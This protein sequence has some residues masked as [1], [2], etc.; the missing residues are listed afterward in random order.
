MASWNGSVVEYFPPVRIEDRPGWWRLDCGC[1]AGIAWSASEYARECDSCKG[2]GWLYVHDP[3][4]V[5]AFGPG[6]QLNG[7][8]NRRSFEQATHAARSEP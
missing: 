7:R 6:G 5:M 2:L 4:L 3:S 1:C 8:M